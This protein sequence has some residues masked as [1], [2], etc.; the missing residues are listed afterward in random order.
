MALY[1]EQTLRIYNSLS[2]KKEVFEPLHQGHVGMYVCGPT[3]YSKVHLGN[4]RTFMSFDMVYRYL[5]HLGYK[6]RYVRNITD[7]G[8]LE[9]DADQGEDKIAKK[10]RLEKI[11]PMEVVQRYT[12]DFHN[13]LRK[14]NLLPPNI[15]PTATG[16]IVEQIEAIKL[17]LDK[18]Y[19]YEKNG[20][21]YFD[22]LKFNKDYDY[23]KL[24]GRRIEDMIANTR[25]LAAQDEKNNPQDFAL[26]KRAEPQHIMRWPSPWGE[27]FPGWH[28]ECTVMSTKYLG[29]TF[30]IHGGGMDLKFP[31]HE[32]EIAQAEAGYGKSPVRYWMHANML[33]LN[34]RKMAK[35]TGNN[36]LPDEIFSGE[37]EILS[38][39]YAPAVVRFFMM[40]AHYT[41]ILDLSDEAL[42]A[43]EKGYHRLM[44]ALELVDSLPES[45]TSEVDLGGWRQ[46]CYDAM[47]DDFNSPVL[48]AQ[49]FEAV[50]WIHQV[51]EGK[52]RLSR[53]DRLLLGETLNAFV[54]DVLGLE[55][56][57]SDT[58]RGETL[59]GVMD[60]LIE[61]RNKARTDKDYATSD[62]IRDALGALG[63]QLKDGKEGTTYSL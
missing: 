48:I 20:S 49:L 36:L 26:W 46:R 60:L 28:L 45:P 42:Q 33:T 6:V 19:A 10:A 15:E 35:S 11:E 18:G 58:G 52:L 43:A 21:V 12:V 17:I 27:G 30:D 53:E 41:S 29:E 9:D 40:Q 57:I 23:G 62:R 54:V 38:K 59:D 31:H 63:I 50:K 47:N 16:H 5:L 7:A 25:D 14:F 55:K 8:H 39:P 34:G 1:Q 22:V 4:C 2:G 51:R 3:V 32:C 44:D 56:V 24:S 61:L 37:N 13:I